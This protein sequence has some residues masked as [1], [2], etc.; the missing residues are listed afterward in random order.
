MAEHDEREEASRR[1]RQLP[2]EEPPPALDAAIRAHARRAVEIHPAPLVPPTGRRQWYFPLAAAAVIVLAV[3]V[4]WHVEREQ[5][6]MV[7]ALPDPAPAATTAPAPA[8]PAAAPPSEARQESRRKAQAPLKQER[9]NTG[10][11][12]EAARDTAALAKESEQKA[13]SDPSSQPELT[14][15]PAPAPAVRVDEAQPRPGAAAR[16]DV[17]RTFGETPE[18][19]LERIA[20]LRAEGRHEDADRELA[21]FRKRYPD[22]KIAPNVLE[23]VEKRDR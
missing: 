20:K 16:S 18:Q 2:R 8:A 7:A 3:A 6:D 23:K 9:Q 10:E 13:R 15:K 11:R 19:W 1:Y 14:A 4:T 22:F 5:P 21:A 12:A 17:A